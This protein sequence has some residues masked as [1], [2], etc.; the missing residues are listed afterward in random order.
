MSEV[1]LQLNSSEQKPK[2]QH[3]LLLAV[4]GFINTFQ[5]TGLN[6]TRLFGLV[7]GW[8]GHLFAPKV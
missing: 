1:Y 6:K 5:K 7:F 8:S 3:G 4:S 2:E